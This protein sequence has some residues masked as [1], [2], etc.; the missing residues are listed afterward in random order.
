MSELELGIPVLQLVEIS[1]SL[2]VDPNH[3]VVLTFFGDPPLNA[4]ACQFESVDVLLA[5]T[6]II[7]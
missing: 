6:S 1:Q 4:L 2:L 5:V 7:S 3:V